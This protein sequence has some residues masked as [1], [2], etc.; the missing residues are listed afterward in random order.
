MR[1]KDS[2]Q[3]FL[4]IWIRRLIEGRS[5]EIWGGGQLRDFTYV[6]DA[7]DAFLLAASSEESNG[8]VF[9]LGG[10][11]VVSLRDL[12]DLVVG[13]NGAGSYDICEFPPEN[14]RIDIGDYYS[15]WSS[16]QS[17]LGWSPAIGLE[18]GLTRT[19]EFYRTNIADY[20]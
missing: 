11:E 4:G 18:D 8:R 16:I 19:I 10:R 12:G 17:A 7:V 9:N 3:T 6:A 1:I 13:A 15:D 5:F 20:V 2:R 14:K